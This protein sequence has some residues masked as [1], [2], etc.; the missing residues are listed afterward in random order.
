ME[1]FST[2]ES[3]GKVVVVYW[4]YGVSGRTVIGS[5]ARDTFVRKAEG[6]RRTLHEKFFTDRPL[7]QDGKPVILG[8]IGLL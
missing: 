3:A 4:V 7:I 5:M 1:I 8:S 6:Y 2:Q